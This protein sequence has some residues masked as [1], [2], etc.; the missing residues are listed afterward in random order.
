MNNATLQN[1]R[2]IAASMQSAPTNWQWI[3]PFMSQRHFGITEAKAK[4]FASRHG[5]EAKEMA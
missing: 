5:G 3:G 2:D 1:F 4:A